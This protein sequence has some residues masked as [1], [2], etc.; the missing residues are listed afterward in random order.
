MWHYCFQ[1]SWY[2]L[3]LELH[4]LSNLAKYFEIVPGLLFLILE[5]KSCNWPLI[6]ISDVAKFSTVALFMNLSSSFNTGVVTKEL[7]DVVPV[8][9]LFL[10]WWSWR[11]RFSC[12]TMLLWLLHSIFHGV[13]GGC[14]GNSW[15]GIKSRL[16]HVRIYGC[17]SLLVC[18]RNTTG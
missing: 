10:C 8:Y 12:G 16:P 7:L 15:L 3:Q 17:A 6:E 18:R 14:I 2:W 13:K 9:G 5:E 4:C 11:W 1:C